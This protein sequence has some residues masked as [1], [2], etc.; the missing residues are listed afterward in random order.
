MF[1]MSFVSLNTPQI[2]HINIKLAST[3]IIL[4]EPTTWLTSVVQRRGTTARSARIV[5][6]KT[7]IQFDVL[8]LRQRKN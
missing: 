5:I 2:S 7:E 8:K 4:V 1:D 3:Q 6:T